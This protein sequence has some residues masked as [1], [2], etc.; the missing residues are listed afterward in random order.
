MA[1]N[2]VLTTIVGQC[3]GGKRVDR[4]KDYLKTAL[5]Y[6]AALLVVFSAIIVCFS[7]QLSGLFVNSPQAAGIVSQYFIIVGIGYVLNTITN[8]F[9]G[10]VNGM[11]KPIKSMLCMVLYYMIIRMPLAWLLSHIGFNLTGI[12]VAVLI[13]HIVAA[14]AAAAVCNMQILSSEK[15]VTSK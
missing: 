7:R 15:I 6:G 1:L 4:I 8:C 3:L 2:M 5:L 14:I 13:S 10:A 9:L 12:W 11:G